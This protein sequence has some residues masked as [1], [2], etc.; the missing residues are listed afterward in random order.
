MARRIKLEN[1][2]LTST[3]LPPAGFK[4]VGYDGT[5]FSQLDS[6]GNIIAIGTGVVPPTP[7][8]NIQTVISSS[9]VTPSAAN[10]LVRITYQCENL[11]ISN[12]VGV[13]FEGKLIRLRIK[14]NSTAHDL[15]FGDKYRIFC[16]DFPA[17]TL[18]GKIMYFDIRYNSD[19]DKWDIVHYHDQYDTNPL[20]SFTIEVVTTNSGTSGNNSFTIPTYI[21][22]TYSYN[23]TTSEQT[24]TSQTS[25]V[26]LN[27]SAPG[28]YQVEI[29]GTFP[30]IYFNNSGDKLKITKVLKW[31][32]ISWQTFENAFY[33][34]ENLDVTAIDIPDLSNV[35]SLKSCFA[36]NWGGSAYSSL[37][38]SNS[39]ISNWQTSNIEDMTAMFRGCENFDVDISNWNVSNVRFMVAMFEYC[40]I[41]N[42]DISGWNVSSVE[43]MSFMFYN[44]WVFNQ[45]LG[46]WNTSSVYGMSYMFS[47]AYQFGADFINGNPNPILTEINNW[48]VSNVLTMQSMFEFS[49]FNETL[50]SWDVSNVTNMASMFFN[51]SFK[52]DITNWDVSSVIYFYSM[53]ESSQ[54][55]SVGTVG[56]IS[57]WSLSTLPQNDISM[58]A[59]FRNNLHFNLDISGWNTNRVTDM[60]E[61]FK[62]SVFNGDITNWDVSNVVNMS[63]MF[64]SSQFN[65]DVSNWNISSATDL[66]FMFYDAYFYDQFINFSLDDVQNWT[67]SAFFNGGVN[68]TSMFANSGMSYLNYTKTLVQFTEIT[69]AFTYWSDNNFSGQFNMVFD[70]SILNPDPL[71]P[72]PTAADSRDYLI[73]KFP[74]SIYDPNAPN[75]IIDGDIV[76]N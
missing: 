1:N 68:M 66:S 29:S 9:V 61:M 31:G 44:A 15:D 76:V 45:Y 13:G 56:D 47:S 26:T 16:D 57:S 63:E 35:T 53:F 70:N 8:L 52:E 17:S 75:W 55:G 33:G 48:D 18:V 65:Q 42:Q 72:F 37:V 14:S 69:A 11:F 10:D 64:R 51:S 43:D 74:P 67:G 12:P 23:V 73:I 41:F 62:G 59:M 24:L 25:D 4:Y 46:L 39:S 50:N 3:G 38:N 54:Y 6:N 60:S 5:T 36:I 58:S 19:D 40:I 2:A 30:S 27:W 71:S 28:T 20:D 34:C 32:S 7:S 49:G 22:Y 21:G